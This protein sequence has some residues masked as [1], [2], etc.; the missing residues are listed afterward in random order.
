M[1]PPANRKRMSPIHKE[2]A[3]GRWYRLS[4]SEQMANIGSEYERTLSWRRKGKPDL[5]RGAFER[6]L[7]LFGLT[8]AERR[9]KGLRLREI[10]RARE[11]VCEEIDSE[12]T[13]N[14]GVSLRLRPSGGLSKDT[15]NIVSPLASDLPV[16]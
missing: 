6:M 14:G 3:A 15:I 12:N 2:M 7:E 9:W 10:E 1:R 4:L 13:T 16:L 8:L 5:A 11:T